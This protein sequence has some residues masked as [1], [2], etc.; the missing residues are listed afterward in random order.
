MIQSKVELL[1]PAGDFECFI[2][3]MN[4][5]ADAVYLGGSKFGARAYANNFTQEE[6]IEALRI[7]HIYGKKVYLTVNTLVK[8]KELSDL[9]P[10][11]KPL[12]DAGLDGVIVQDLGVFRMIQ[13]Y[14][15]EVELHASTQ[16]TLTGEYGAEFLKEIGAVRIVPAREL[17]L[18]EIKAMKDKTGLEIET[19][20]HGAMCYAYSGQCLFSSI[21]GGRSGN[22]GRCAGPCRLPYKAKDKKDIYPLS[23]KDMYTLSE[24]PKLIEAGI[25]SFKIEGR[26]KSPEYV[27]GVTAMYRK[28]ID[29][30][31]ANPKA[32]FHVSKQDEEMMRGLYIRTDICQG[33]YEQ[34]NSKNMVTISEPGYAGGKD[35]VLEEIR[36]KY[37]NAK[38]VMDITGRAVIHKDEP[39][40][41]QLSCVMSDGRQLEA[42]VSGDVVSKAQNRPLD[43]EDIRNRLGK[44][45]DTYFKLSELELDADADAFMPIKAL[46][47]LRRAACEK[48]EEEILHSH[49][50]LRQEKAKKAALQAQDTLIHHAG[51]E[52][53]EKQKEICLAVGVQTATQLSCAVK[54]ESVSYIYVNADLVLT[55]RQQLTDRMKQYADKEYYLALPHILRKR[56]Y[57]YLEKYLDAL[58]TMPFAGVLIRNAEELQWLRKIG[59]EGHYIADYTVYAWN[60]EAVAF[61]NR[62]F[63]RLTVPVELNR[64][65]LLQLEESCPKEMM[66]YGRIPLMYSANCVRKTLEKCEKNINDGQLIYYLTD[67][68]RNQF[69]ILQNCLHCYNILYNTVPLSLHGQLDGME[70]FGIEVY[71]LEF[72]TEDKAQTESVLSY[73]QKR[74]VLDEPCDYP[75]EEFTNGHYKRGVE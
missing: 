27:A 29:L 71:R 47:E 73:Y 51:R 64:K 72:T 69:P 15:P 4:A 1:A 14:F 8:E 57:P 16:M 25:D 12:C 67:R 48:L 42:E 18:D 30:Y 21:L 9:V 36:R 20:I 6:I 2:A 62:Y 24:I 31:L 55:D 35:A 74:I 22:R 17:S 19:F 66:V 45:G 41:L 54:Q 28:Y 50:R 5:G 59:Y 38:R 34:H 10:Y 68:Y 49:S 13:K 46:N 75:Y 11:L 7:A 40:R 39:A 61:Y 3:A 60:C 63:E 23:L 37:L 43:L 65:E 58:Q 56:S 33:Y 26:M 44:M 70:R 53:V 52:T 32:P